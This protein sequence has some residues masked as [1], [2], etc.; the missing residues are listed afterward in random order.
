MSTPA[1]IRHANEADMAAVNALY[2]ALI[3]AT[4]IAWTDECETLEDRI[5]AYRASR[6]AGY[7]VLVAE[8]ERG[9]VGFCSYRPFRDHLIWPGYRHTMEHTI[10]VADHSQGQGIG[11][12]LL[13]ALMAIAGQQGVHV[14]VAGIDSANQPSLRFHERLGFVEVA[15]LPEVGRKFDRRLDLI[16]MQRI[17]TSDRRA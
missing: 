14:L 8:G 15:H 9:V 3:P 5:T 11:R 10:H 7:P 16:L 13:S 2:N 1:P 6:A 12:A 4:T 17:I